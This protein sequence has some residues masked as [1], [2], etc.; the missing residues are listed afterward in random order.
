MSVTLLDY[1][2]ITYSNASPDN[3]HFMGPHS[4]G[5]GSDH[6]DYMDI[7][8][9]TATGTPKVGVHSYD[10]GGNTGWKFLTSN[11]GDTNT[12]WRYQKTFTSLPGS[13]FAFP[14]KKSRFDYN[15]MRI[16]KGGR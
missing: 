7:Q 16:R 13:M 8:Y 9:S 5:L 1:A 11:I 12:G 3:Q 6:L 2:Y 10:R 4:D 15:L 14:F